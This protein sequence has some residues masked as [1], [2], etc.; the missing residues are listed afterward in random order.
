VIRLGLRMTV[1]GGREAALRLVLTALAVALGTGMLLITLACLNAVNRQNGRYA[2]IET[3]IGAHG[4]GSVITGAGHDPT[5]WQLTADEVDNDII[6]RIDVAPTGPNPPV[7]PGIPSLPKAGEYL[8]S[9]A[10]RGL[11]ATMPASQLADRF[12]GRLVGT[13]GPAGLPGPDSLV[14]IVGRR[15][16]EL[17]GRGGAEL[18]DRI[19]TTSPSSCN[20]P[21]CYA[22]GIDANGIDLV[23]AVTAA[24]LLFPVLVFI[25]T[26]SRLAAARREQRFAAMR[27]VGA[28]PRQVTTVSAVESSVASVAG[29]ALG[30]VVF[31]LT[32]PVIASIPFT[33][34]RFY[35][36][37][38]RLSAADVLLVA[39]GVPVAAALASR[40]ALRRVQISPLGASRRTTPEAP[41]PWRTIPVA[42]GLAEL[43]WFVHAGRPTS[44]PDQIGVFLTGILLTMVGL[45]LAGPW[46]TMVG[47]RLLVRRSRRPSLLIAGRRLADD[48]RAGFRSVSGLVLA[49]FV[50]SVALGVITTIEAYDVPSGGHVARSTVVQ[51]VSTYEA[52]TPRGVPSLPTG[53]LAGLRAIPGVRGFA[54][55][56]AVPLGQQT[57]EVR[58]SRQLGRGQLVDGAISC[59]ELAQVPS[60]G[61]CPTD[62]AVAAVPSYVDQGGFADRTWTGSTV[63]VD[64]L[65]TL[66]IL[67][68]DVTTDGRTATIETVRTRLLTEGAGW[69]TP[70]TIRELA[71]RG[72]AR[73]DEQ[74]RRLAD[75]VIFSSLVIAGC[76][77]AVSVVSGLNDRKRPFSLLRLTGAPLAMLRRV[78]AL[79]SAVPLLLLAA[80]SSGTGFLAAGLFLRAQLEETLRAPG[81]GYAAIVGA[82]LL[83]SLGTIAATLPMLASITGPEVA[84]NETT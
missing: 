8:A 55:I 66:P 47:A 73:L 18:V 28:S 16:D 75:V 43:A 62:A 32:R 61:R 60:L 27:L 82:G 51:D 80:I 25:G 24:A 81:L 11:L 4:P 35:Q 67:A 77:L 72:S 31:V 23:L 3:G 44:T 5:W 34:T 45:V 29:V 37:D 46:L 78:V 64:Q 30:F 57:T 22:I 40:V 10:L 42:L 69:E 7:P 38:L 6:G 26:A 9:P 13:I 70:V 33:G 68:F 19:S 79:E 36:R 63:T 56:R 52:G 2:W 71:L 17:R 39:V 58:G 20:G 50:T 1:H 14:V 84:R 53:L 12:P 21:A 59:A 83:A 15:V 65:A 74:Y 41:R 54:M 48:P 76:S 49:L